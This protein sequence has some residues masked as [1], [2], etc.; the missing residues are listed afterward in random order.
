MCQVLR[1]F[2]FLKL[3]IISNVSSFI[4]YNLSYLFFKLLII[5]LTND[6][7]YRKWLSFIVIIFS[8]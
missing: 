8:I 2:A 6:G 7:I 5:Y 3:T 1:M 4:L